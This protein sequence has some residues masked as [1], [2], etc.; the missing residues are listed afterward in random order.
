MRFVLLLCVFLLFMSSCARTSSPPVSWEEQVA[1]IQKTKAHIDS[2]A[3]VSYISVSP[4]QFDDIDGELK[5]HVMFLDPEYRISYL[6]YNDIH[7]VSSHTISKHTGTQRAYVREDL[8]QLN[9]VLE[10]SQLSPRDLIEIVRQDYEELNGT[11]APVV[12]HIAL[13]IDMLERRETFGK[14]V[15]LAR[16]SGA[17][18]SVRLLFIDPVSGKVLLRENEGQ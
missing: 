11:H 17:Q 3:Q 14:V 1:F 13:G 5:I 15:W 12:V 4:E 2:N 10:K 7:L 16:M 9:T 6:S 8:V 18:Q